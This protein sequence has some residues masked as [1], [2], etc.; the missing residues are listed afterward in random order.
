M[1]GANKLSI[2]FATKVCCNFPETVSELPANKAILTG[3]PIRQELLSGNPQKALAFTGL[4]SEKP[5]IMVIGGSLGAVAVNN[6]VR[7][8][9]PELL[10]DFQV[11]HLCGKGKLDSSLT[12]TKGYVQY[13]YIKDELAD[14]FALADIVIS[15]AG[16]NA[17]CEISALKKPNLLIPLS[18]RASRGDQI[19]NA[20]SFEKL[21]YSLVLEEEEITNQKLLESIQTLYQNRD[22][23][24]QAMEKSKQTDSIEQI[25]Q[26][27]E[28]AVNK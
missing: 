10:K 13:E 26:L 19:L 5:V 9:L 16:A 28:Q 24:I 20:R 8:I 15:R 4:S 25:V 7:A 3:T 1:V 6:A 12:D 11:I 23:Y 17:I 21:G 27:F 2:P 14:L 18:A 22:S